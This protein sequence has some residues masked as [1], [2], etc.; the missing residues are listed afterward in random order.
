MA[1]RQHGVVSRG[2]LRG[3]GLSDG[4]IEKAVE[5]GRLHAAFRGTFGVGTP[6]RGSH[7]RMLAAVLACGDGAL[8][9]HLAAAYLLGLRDHSPSSVEV[10]APGESG[11]AIEGVRR[12]HVRLP[13]GT[14]AGQCR[15][16]PCTSP[17]RTVVDVAG[18]LGERGVRAM[19]E[20]AAVRSML[21]LA[22]I[23]RVMSR[24]RR[25]GAPT[26]RRI[27]R[28]WLPRGEAA[29]GGGMALRSELEARLLA[30]IGAAGLPTPICNQAVQADGMTLV[31]DFLWPAQ[32]LVVE[33]DG[34]RFH[35]HSVAF[36]RDRRRDRALQ[37]AGYRVVRLTY[38]QIESEPEAAIAAIRRLLANAIG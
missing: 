32:R 5:T 17:S 20:R 19:V 21:D 27:L 4:A 37:V 9:S 34:E 12:R 36:E 14:E 13:I 28:E 29:A 10:I 22:E 8:V 30:M 33:A 23:E 35:G 24:G 6:P 18:M 16:V 2:Q 1:A 7:A 26:L 25:R 38:R 3:L 11:R 15:G 31:V